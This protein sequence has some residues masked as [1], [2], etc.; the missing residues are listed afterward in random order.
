LFVLLSLIVSKYLPIYINLHIVFIIAP[1]FNTSQIFGID[2]LAI[3]CLLIF[4]AKASKYAKDIEHYISSHPSS[5][6]GDL[7]VIL[8]VSNWLALLL[9]SSSTDAIL[10][11]CAYGLVFWVGNTSG[12]PI[13]LSLLF[14]R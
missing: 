9:D 14:A 3:V 6:S 4:G 12:T 8:V 10:S 1:K 13:A 2:D 5:I 7:Y 11:R